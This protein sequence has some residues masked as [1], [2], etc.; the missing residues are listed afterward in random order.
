MSVT[1]A[2]GA[3]AARS[4]LNP[5]RGVVELLAQDDGWR[6]LPDQHARLN[7]EAAL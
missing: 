7:L 4:E 3:V 6:Q 5:V 2:A 1:A